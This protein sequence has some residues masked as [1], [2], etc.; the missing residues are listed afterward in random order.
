VDEIE[1]EAVVEPID[2]TNTCSRAERARDPLSVGGAGGPTL[3]R[4][5]R[6]RRSGR[7]GR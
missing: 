4:G 1:R 7:R 2:P 3:G 6:R 5:G